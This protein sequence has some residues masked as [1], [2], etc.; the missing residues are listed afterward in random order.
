[1]IKYFTLLILFINNALFAD[2]E[3][4]V[5]DINRLINNKQYDEANKLFILALTEYDASASIYFVGGQVSIKLDN[6]DDANKY[7]IK[8]IELDNKNEEYR[9]TQ[10]NLEKLK[11][12]LTSARKTFDNGRYNDA[13]EEHEQIIFLI[14]ST[15][16][17]LR[18]FSALKNGTCM[19]QSPVREITEIL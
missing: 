14:S 6:L 17:L 18:F 13:I 15:K 8:A 2:A 9:S 12:S 5:N 19:K 3:S 16:L 11:N 4:Y 1:M 7:I 10:E